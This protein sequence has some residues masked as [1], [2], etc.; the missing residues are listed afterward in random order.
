MTDRPY[1]DDDLRTEAARLHARAARDTDGKI[2]QAVQRRWGSQL[3]VDQ[4]DE[5]GDALVDVLDRAADTSR[6]AVDLG[7]DGLTPAEHSITVDPEQPRVRVLFA[8]APEM[9]E[10]QQDAFVH[11][12]A[13]RIGTRLP[14]GGDR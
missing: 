13:G 5:A 11:V 1:T 14:E 8:F 10:A 4:L 12:I 7:A 3:D 9:S 6:W 2:R